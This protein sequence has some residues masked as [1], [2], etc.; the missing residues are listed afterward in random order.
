MKPGTHPPYPWET[1]IS[2][3]VIKAFA[4]F[5]CLAGCAQMVPFEPIAVP[6]NLSEAGKAAQQLIN[7][8]NIALTAAY[9][10]VGERRKEKLITKGEAFKILNTLDDYSADLDKAQEI[11]NLGND[12]EA[13]G[14]AE[15]TKRLID[16]LRKTVA[17]KARQ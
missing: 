9:E 8:G 1:L 3:R 11:L 10:L 2:F 6:E 12:L 16:A 15:V 7:E 17:E 13:K 14:K 4:L 5:L